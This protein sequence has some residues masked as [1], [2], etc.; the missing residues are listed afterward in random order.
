MTEIG[1]MVGVAL[2]FDEKSEIKCPFNETE[3]KVKIKQEKESPLNDDK[4][5]EQANNGQVLG[6]NMAR[7][8]RAGWG[9]PG[10]WNDKTPP[11]ERIK[12]RLKLES[13]GSPALM[14]TLDDFK[15]PG[16]QRAYNWKAAA[17]HLI[18]G[19]AAL[20]KSNL[21]KH[22][23]IEGAKITS[24]GKT[25]ELSSHIGYNVNGNH[26]G[27]W[28]P[29]NYAI[30][31][32]AYGKSWSD[33]D[34]AWQFRYVNAVVAKARKQYHDTHVHYSTNVLKALDQLSAML[35]N[36]IAVCKE[37]Q[38][39]ADGK[40]APPYRLKAALYRISRVLGMRVRGWPGSWR[41][42]YITSDHYKVL[43]RTFADQNRSAL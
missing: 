8:G 33:L 39:K 22:F 32:G 1:E 14:V 20:T 13:N 18:P 31:R 28:L 43:L 6:K 10:T 36:H 23:M 42:P 7:P 19:E 3:S 38:D 5:A 17:H 27:A 21:Y 4:N 25:F 24:G 12:P 41:E 11:P 26:N 29:G 34:A 35:M 30:R 9:R 16:Q 40:I 15:Q 2:S 37:C